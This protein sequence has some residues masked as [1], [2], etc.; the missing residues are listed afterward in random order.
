MS[1][2]S[3]LSGA[4]VAPSPSALGGAAVAPS[5]KRLLSIAGSVGVLL[6]LLYSAMPLSPSPLPGPPP[7]P[8]FNDDNTPNHR[9][10]FPALFTPAECASLIAFARGHHVKVEPGAA[11]TEWLCTRSEK[12]PTDCWAAHD[13]AWARDRLVGAFR[14]AVGERW[15]EFARGFSEGE[16]PIE[17]RVL[18]FGVGG[19][20]PWRVDAT[21][22]ASRVS[23]N[24]TQLVSLSVQLDD[25][26]GYEGG[27]LIL[28]DEPVP[29]AIGDAT[30]Y[31]S[32]TPHT[33]RP[34]TRGVRRALVLGVWAP[35]AWDD[36]RMRH[37]WRRLA[38]PLFGPM[39]RR[40]AARADDTS[41]GHVHLVYAR[42]LQGLASA[43]RV[44]DVPR[45][46]FPTNT[47]AIEQYQKASH[48]LPT[49]FEAV[50]GYSVAL[51]AAERAEDAAVA[52]EQTTR[53]QPSD[54][55]T[56]NDLA[57]TYTA[58]GRHDD[59]IKAARAAVKLAPRDATPH[60]LL[61]LA[62]EASGLAKHVAAARK[63]VE[64]S[65][66]VARSADAQA[67]AH[68]ELARAR[69]R[70]PTD[71]KREQAADL[72]SRATA[73]APDEAYLHFEHG[74]H[75]GQSNSTLNEA[76][77]AMKRALELKPNMTTDVA[78]DTEAPAG[79][80]DIYFH[81]GTMLHTLA[82]Q[83]DSDE[84]LEHARDV[85][86]VG[87]DLRPTHGEMAYQAATLA[88]R[89]SDKPAAQKLLQ[90]AIDA[91]TSAEERARLAQ[92]MRYVRMMPTMGGRL[93]APK[94]PAHPGSVART[95]RMS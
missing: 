30:L 51:L 85:L 77:A 25:D 38:T 83:S 34:V 40:M 49:S 70:E 6:A 21:P 19:L 82:K 80:I 88:S 2:P 44:G 39:L 32:A 95:F 59:A 53:L 41:T 73:I 50:R 8:S 13:V 35:M 54:A 92:M 29:R 16:P 78:T 84:A 18:T 55:P 74:R 89:E 15:P 58:V 76:V 93:K 69:M 20:L 5:Q 64:T 57:A 4:A 63:A 24:D 45:G 62:L 61:G 37:I 71:E 42:H 10:E 1:A 90:R 86:E 47:S 9:Q 11:R 33:V 23:A 7:A 28:G 31:L 36:A 17:M 91:A 43:G 27:D 81:L 65:L 75:L 68:V 94:R 87:S 60:R 79:A 3:A 52:L 12:E 72:F 14:A 46:L 26:E 22:T 48:L 66:K 67:R 56:T